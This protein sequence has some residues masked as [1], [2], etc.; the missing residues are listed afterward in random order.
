MQCNKPA[1]L[2]ILFALAVLCIRFEAKVTIVIL[3]P[4]SGVKDLI[5]QFDKL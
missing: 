1:S 3:D 2:A 5:K 4:I